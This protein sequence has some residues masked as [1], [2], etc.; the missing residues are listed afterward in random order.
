MKTFKQTSVFSGLSR[1]FFLMFIFLNSGLLTAQTLPNP[2]ELIPYRKGD[3]WG[4]CDRNK[5]IVIGCKYDFAGPFSEGLSI[6]KLNGKWGF[7][8]ANGNEYW[9]E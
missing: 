3:K 8:D 1:V 5:K 9:E 2:P 4:F 7:I 6:V